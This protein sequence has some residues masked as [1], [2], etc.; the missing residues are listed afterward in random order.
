[1]LQLGREILSFILHFLLQKECQA[2]TTVYTLYSQS[3]KT[4]TLRQILVVKGNGKGKETL[5]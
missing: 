5:F 3:H 1:M 4:L 2:L